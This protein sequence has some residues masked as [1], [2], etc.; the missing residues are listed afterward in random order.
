[1]V[2]G[3]SSVFEMMAD[4]DREL[5]KA[6]KR[7]AQD[8]LVRL[9]SGEA[10]K[11]DL[12]ALRDWRA[13]SP[14]HADAFAQACR[15]W[16]TIKP[17]VAAVAWQE[18]GRP[19]SFLRGRRPITR[20]VF[21]GGGIAVA[22]AAVTAIVYPSAAPSFSSLVADYRTGKG[23]QRRLTIGEGV[24]VEMNTETSLNVPSSRHGKEIELIQGE[25]AITAA[26]SPQEPLTVIAS[27]GRITASD[28]TF[29]VL[30]TG[31]TTQ[32]TCLAGL[33]QVWHRQRTATVGPDQQL[34]YDDHAVEAAI[35]VDPAVV[36]A[37][38]QGQ[39][40][41]HNTPLGHVIEEV[42]RY[43]RGRIIVTNSDLSKR[44]V[45]AQ[46]K[47]E[48]L[49]DVVTQIHQVFGAHVHFFPG[50]IVFLS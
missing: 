47:L 37:W 42:N 3:V 28:A 38:R 15:F 29:N 26:V 44:L 33:V 23:E 24:S 22:A 10:T 49:G 1:M 31:S 46:F 8:W 19:L 45:T 34:S 14:L 11:D 5:A 9:T 2:R 40:I 7:E 17:A 16:K 39:L 27:Q 32:I 36:T 43:R 13:Q 41:F 18:G 50:N 6:L 30:C 21:L 20:R 25:T 48:Q 12:Q 35:T 4:T